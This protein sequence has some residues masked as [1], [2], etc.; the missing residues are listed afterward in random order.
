MAIES[1]HINRKKII[2]VLLFIL[3]V[4]GLFMLGANQYRM[5][6]WPFEDGFESLSIDEILPDQNA[7]IG[8]VFGTE[9]LRVYN[10]P[11]DDEFPSGPF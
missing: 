5:K 6:W 11:I 3:M 4:V 8:S 7:K 2:K 1:M 9:N 10:L